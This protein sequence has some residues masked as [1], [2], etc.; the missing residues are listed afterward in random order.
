MYVKL[1]PRIQVSLIKPNLS[2]YSLCYA[3]A[4]IKLTDTIF[5]WLRQGNTA[6]FKELWQ[7]WRA[8]GSIVSYLTGLRFESR[9]SRF[10]DECV[11]TRPTSSKSVARITFLNLR[12]YVKIEKIAYR[13]SKIYK[14]SFENYFLRIALSRFF[15]YIIHYNKSTLKVVSFTVLKMFWYI[16]QTSLATVFLHLLTLLSTSKNTYVGALLSTFCRHHVKL[17]FLRRHCRFLFANG[18]LKMK[19]TQ[20]PKREHKKLS[21]R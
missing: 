12:I 17:S 1:S 11:P 5:V 19:K 16:S 7:R 15:L 8:V 4:C 20:W 21:R 10:S 14:L 3:D 13:T 6:S 2:L 9:I 18:V